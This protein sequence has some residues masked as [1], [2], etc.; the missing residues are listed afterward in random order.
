ME[1]H[2]SITVCEIPRTGS[3]VGLS[4]L[5]GRKRADATEQLNSSLTVSHHVRD[6]F[7]PTHS[8]AA[9]LFPDLSSYKYF[10]HFSVQCWIKAAACFT[11]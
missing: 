5:W 11:F 10:Q 6:K 4:S 1:T 7:P 2:S 9:E 3:L 8:W